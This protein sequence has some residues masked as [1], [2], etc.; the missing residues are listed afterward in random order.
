[1]KRANGREQVLS[2]MISVMMHKP[3]QTTMNR[4]THLIANTKRADQR[5]RAQTVYVSKKRQTALGRLR[6]NQ[7]RPRHQKKTERE[8]IDSNRSQKQAAAEPTLSAV[9]PAH[10]QSESSIATYGHPERSIKISIQP[11]RTHHRPSA[12]TQ[13]TRGNATGEG[14]LRH[15]NQVKAQHAIRLSAP[16]DRGHARSCRPRSKGASRPDSTSESHWTQ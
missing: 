12:A 16:N 8:A 11:A 1:M 7:P 5:E 13:H 6:K 4:A 14:Y 10:G 3:T 2:H 9:T 15:A